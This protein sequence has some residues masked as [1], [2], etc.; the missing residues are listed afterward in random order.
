MSGDVPRGSLCTSNEVS[1]LIEE[2]QYSLG[3]GPCVDA[4]HQDCPV[5]EPNLAE[6]SSPRWLAFAGPAVDAG[7]RA[8]FG[9]PLQVGAVRLGALNSYRDQPAL[10]DEQHADALVAADIVAQAILVLQATIVAWP[11]WPQTWWPGSCVSMPRAERRIDC[12]EFVRREEAV[13]SREGV[14]PSVGS[15]SHAAR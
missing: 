10:T 6:P 1:A 11:R 9:F 3:E 7:V 15:V 13:P 2:L 14:H 5:L 12:H 8:I 4:Y